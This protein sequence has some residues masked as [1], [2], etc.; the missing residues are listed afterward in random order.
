M[1]KERSSNSFSKSKIPIFFAIIIFISVGLSL[2]FIDQRYRVKNIKLLKSGKELYPVNGLNEF[3]EANLILL[4]ESDAQSQILKLNPFLEKVSVSKIYPDTLEVSVVYQTPAAY[5]KV[6]GGYVLLSATA[7]VLA[8][9]RDKPA[10]DLP[11]IN[12]YQALPFQN[13][14]SGQKVLFRDIVDSLY[15]LQKLQNLRFKINSIDIAGFYMLGL[16]TNEKKFYFSSEKDRSE[17]VYL[18]ESS[19]RELKMKGQEFAT[20]DVR[21][22]NPVV[23]F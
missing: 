22:D 8:K 9:S 16:Y 19:V 7:T 10:T 17:Q 2:F 23:T 12:Y 6:N 18:L 15:F 21:Y 5:L 14:Q 3:D 4:S 20:L 11:E 1:H 13:Y